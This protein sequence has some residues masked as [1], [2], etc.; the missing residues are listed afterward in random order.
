MFAQIVPQKNALRQ[1][2]V[3]TLSL[4]SPVWLSSSTIVHLKKMEQAN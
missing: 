3:L 4:Q 1:G 2:T